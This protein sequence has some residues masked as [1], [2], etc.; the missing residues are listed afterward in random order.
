MAESWSNTTWNLLELRIP[1]CGLCGGDINRNALRLECQTCTLP[2]LCLE[3]VGLAT[4]VDT[5]PR[6]RTVMCIRTLLYK[7][8]I[9]GVLK[10]H[11]CLRCPRPAVY[12]GYFRNCVAGDYCR[13]HARR[14]ALREDVGFRECVSLLLPNCESLHCPSVRA[15][16]KHGEKLLCS[17]CIVKHT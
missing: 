7:L 11:P 5:C 9:A 13:E 1:S 8:R 10:T 17:K 3:C 2:Q 16:A 6:C 14:L 15:V 12:R 4:L